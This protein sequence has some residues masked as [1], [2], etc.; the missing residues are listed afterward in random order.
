MSDRSPGSARPGAHSGVWS[1][2]SSSC[3]GAKHLESSVMDRPPQRS[4]IVRVGHCHDDAR[5]ARSLPATGP[6]QRATDRV[7]S[8]CWCFSS[9]LCAWLAA[10]S[11][12]RLLTNQKNLILL[13][14]WR[15]VGVVFLVLMVNGQM[16]ALWAL[17]AGIGDVIVGVDGAVDRAARRDAS[18]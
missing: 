2:R 5:A 9:W 6:G 8:R 15:L 11:L 17:P 18:G 4:R 3:C 12:R 14:L 7:R 10:P 13:N 1:S 16:P